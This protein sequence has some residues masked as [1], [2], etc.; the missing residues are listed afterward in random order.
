MFDDHIRKWQLRKNAIRIQ[1]RVIP[2]EIHEDGD[3]NKSAETSLKPNLG[4]IDRWKREKKLVGTLEKPANKGKQ[5]VVETSKATDQRLADP[6]LSPL[7]EVIELSDG[8]AR[9]LKEL[10]T[11]WDWEDIPGSAQILSSFSSGEI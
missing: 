10:Q 9:E 7:R 6:A 4:K 11:V 8:S 2:E 5:P 1:R 3:K